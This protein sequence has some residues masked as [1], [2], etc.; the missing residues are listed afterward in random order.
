MKRVGRKAEEDAVRQP[1]SAGGQ[2]ADGHIILM[3][4]DRDGQPRWWRVA[5]GRI[6]SRSHGKDA[7]AGV[8]DGLP[9][10]LVAAPSV[11]LVR[12]V[13][14][15]AAMPPAQARVVAVRR[16]LE[17]GATSVDEMHGAYAGEAGAGAGAAKR[18]EEEGKASLVSHQV[19]V[20]ARA[21]MEQILR[22]AA[23]VGV[24]PTIIL[25]LAALLPT[26]RQGYVRASFGD[27]AVVRGPSWTAQGDEPWL[28]DVIGDDPVRHL[29]PE[30]GEQALIAALARP[31]VN[32]RSGIFA[33]RRGGGVDARRA[34]RLML[35]AGLALVLTILMPLA[36]IVKYHWN[37]AQ[38][39][40][41]TLE[42]A[43]PYAPD[44]VD[45][46]QAAADID[47][48]VAA[49]GGAY[50]FTGPLSG[51]VQAMQG[52]PGV[53]LSVL[54]LREDGL[55]HATLASAQAEDINRV[56]MAV[57]AA[58]YTITATSSTDPGGRVLAEI[59]VKP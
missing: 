42:L 32:L 28:K 33:P 22:W 41:K 55:L 49:Q 7:P 36:L 37:A 9:V 40:K 23:S 20:M 18:D 17:A 56:L 34:R 1:D 50:A 14:L 29:T 11:A 16:A 21:D 8:G 46:A 12:T 38:M 35:W 19:A 30:E 3:P 53:S 47:R 48:L 4:F 57:Q 25:P 10:M 44:A 2:A 27:D 54:G 31:P 5:D 26:P 24:Q 52:V 58:G 59:T 39:D 15:D 45:A 51:L 6:I 43:R 13:E